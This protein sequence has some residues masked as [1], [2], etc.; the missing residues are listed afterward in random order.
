MS[1]TSKHGNMRENKDDS[2]LG[3]GLPEAG[4]VYGWKEVSTFASHDQQDMQMCD[5]QVYSIMWSDVCA[6]S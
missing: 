3:H 1:M 5:Q 2:V 6:E 4:E